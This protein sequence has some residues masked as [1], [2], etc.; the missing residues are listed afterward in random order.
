MQHTNP[1]M[2]KGVLGRFVRLAFKDNQSIDVDGPRTFS[3]TCSKYVP[4]DATTPTQRIELVVPLGRHALV[5]HSS[6]LRAHQSTD[7]DRHAM[8]AMRTVLETQGDVR[9]KANRGNVEHI[10][11][12][13]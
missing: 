12:V 11:S 5:D 13:E 2:P 6:R 1:G 9:L 7:C 3:V 10:W 4:F 8:S